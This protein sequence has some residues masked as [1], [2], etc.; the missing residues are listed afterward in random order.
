MAKEVAIDI[1]PVGDEGQEVRPSSFCAAVH[2]DY[3]AAWVRRSLDI[4]WNSRERVFFVEFIGQGPPDVPMTNLLTSRV[5]VHVANSSL[6]ECGSSLRLGDYSITTEDH[7]F[8]FS[9]EFFC[10]SCSARFAAEKKGL[11][12]YL[13]N[14]LMG[15]KRLE[16]SAT[17]I[18]IE[19]K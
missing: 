13:E 9:G 8:A 19:R 18:G 4:K 15:L 10:P 17:G 14:W 12:K 7:D 3:Y 2:F 16:I 1:K 6:C 5:P 11:K